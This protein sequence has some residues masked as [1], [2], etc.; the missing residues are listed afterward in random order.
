MFRPIRGGESG[1]SSGR[2]SPENSG[3]I[4]YSPTDSTTGTSRAT[5]SR[6]DLMPPSAA[7][8]GSARTRR[9]APNAAW[10]PCQ[11]RA[12]SSAARSR[13]SAEEASSS[14]V[15]SRV[16]A[17]AR[18]SFR[19]RLRPSPSDVVRRPSSADSTAETSRSSRWRSRERERSR[20]SRSEGGDQLPAEGVQPGLASGHGRDRNHGRR[21]VSQPSLDLGADVFERLRELRARE[22]IRLAQQDAPVDPGAAQPGQQRQIILVGGVPRDQ[23]EAE[24]A[25]RQ[26]GECRSRGRRGVGPHARGVQEANPLG[27]A[28][29]ADLERRHA[30]AV[31]GVLGLRR[32]TG[33]GIDRMPLRASRREP[34]QHLRLPSL[35][36]QRKSSHGCGSDGQHRGGDEGVDQR[37]LTRADPAEDAYVGGRRG[38]ALRQGRDFGIELDQLVLAGRR[39]RATKN[40][41]GR[42]ADAADLGLEVRVAAAAQQ[43][44][45]AG[46]ESLELGRDGAHELGVVRV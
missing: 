39:E 22:Q 10:P 36:P 29:R 2:A 8:G 24:V 23:H 21:R 30:E 5:S 4:A 25:A 3:G 26:P 35:D 37:R 9:T 46:D 1:G 43:V 16:R 28:R 33:Y 45:E 17:E 34:H 42:A 44:E 14:S 15:I 19:R 27:R 31:A 6:A 40:L 13:A 7:F 41:P 12:A 38:G 32:E 11:A 20:R 18:S